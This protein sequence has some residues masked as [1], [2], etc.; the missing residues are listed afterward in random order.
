[1]TRVSLG[2]FTI[3]TVRALKRSILNLFDRHDGGREMKEQ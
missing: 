2:G 1:M 3:G